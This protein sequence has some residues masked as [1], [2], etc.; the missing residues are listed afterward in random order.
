MQKLSSN[1]SIARFLSAG[2]FPVMAAYEKG[3]PTRSAPCFRLREG[4]PGG[5]EKF[6]SDFDCWEESS[7]FSARVQLKGGKTFPSE[8]VDYF[9]SKG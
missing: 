3:R 9:G 2:T 8:R 6:C 5:R 4:M 1:Y 7:Q